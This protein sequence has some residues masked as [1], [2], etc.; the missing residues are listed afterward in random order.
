[1]KKILLALTFA[2]LF[3]SCGNDKKSNDNM[4]KKETSMSSGESKQERN[5]KVI[6]ANMEA[7]GRADIDA[8]LKDA[9]TNFTDYTDGSIPP[10][11]NIDS[12]RGLLKMMFTSIESYKPSNI[13]LIAEGDYVAAYADWS[14]TFKN[15][16]MSIKATGKMVSFPDVDIFKFNEEGKIIEHRSV[17]NMGLALM[18]SGMM[19]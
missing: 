19:K 10:V 6:M 17:Q 8:M 15:D 9:A 11:T 1:M 12:L 18:A 13:M 4:D 2:G 7:A 14:G 5:K 3:A 16:M